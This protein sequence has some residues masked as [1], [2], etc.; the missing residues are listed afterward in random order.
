MAMAEGSMEA[1]PTETRILMMKDTARN[2]DLSSTKCR[3]QKQRLLRGSM[4]STVRCILHRLPHSHEHGPGGQA[5]GAGVEV[6][7][8]PSVQHA[9]HHHGDVPAQCCKL[10]VVQ[11][12]LF[13]SDN[14]SHCPFK[15]K[16][17]A[18]SNKHLSV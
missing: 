18:T 1:S 3:E 16:H 10:Q 13:N 15:W 6:A 9:G 7:Q 11:I 17:Q 14:S 12:Q 5:G 8:V 2:M 4:I